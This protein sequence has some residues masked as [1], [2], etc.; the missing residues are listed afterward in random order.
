M[1]GILE[2]INRWV[3]RHNRNRCSDCGRKLVCP[4][5]HSEHAI[6]Q[7]WYGRNHRHYCIDCG[8]EDWI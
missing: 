8:F 1:S 4:K 2:R 5:C 7:G 6:P 3:E